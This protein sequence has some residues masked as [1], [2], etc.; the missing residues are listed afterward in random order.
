MVERDSDAQPMYV[1]PEGTQREQG[2]S[3]QSNNI[4]AARIVG[5]T[6][7]TTLGPK[8]MDKMLV[9]SMGNVTITNDGVTIL[10]EME[11]EH[12]AAKMVVEIAKTQE[13][14]VG[15]G[16][17][18]AVVLA[19]ELLKRA[20]SLIDQKI[21]PTIITKGYRMAAEKAIHV[22]KEMSIRCT[23]DDIE[24]LEGIA[25]TAM[26]GKG[27][28]NSKDV[29]S[30]I[31]VEAIRHIS[32]SKVAGDGS[33]VYRKNLKIESRSGGFVEE[34]ELVKGVVLDKKKANP[35]MPSRV[36]SARIALLA[37][38][39]EIKDTETDAK[40]QITR[41]EQM[42]DFLDMEEKMLRKMVDKVKGSGANVVLCQ[43][44]IDDVAQHFLAKEGIL[45]VRRVDRSDM[46]RISRASGAEIVNNLDSLSQESLGR[47]EIV[48]EKMIGEDPMVFIR[49]CEN[50]RSVT[51]LVR[52][53]TEHVVEEAKRALED[54]AGDIS[55]AV[56][57]GQIVGGAGAPEIE[58]SRRLMD[59][60]QGLSGREQLSVKAFA[61]SME[62]I[63]KTLA[64]NAGLDPIDTIVELRAAHDKGKR[65]AG[66]DVTTGG[67]MDSLESGV[68]EPL[69]VKTQAVSSA[70]DVAVLILR[71]DDVISSGRQSREEM[72]T[73]LDN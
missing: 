39:L 16:T 7:R 48:E 17:T 9:D 47:S 72:D 29:L 20:E 49:G 32:A 67:V 13:D 69:K 70:S 28:E 58:L 54:A 61:E 63:P 14:E 66:I 11:I 38:P 31:V 68:A 1:L 40:I 36:G 12:P 6:V 23:K 26:T 57:S 46:E 42:Q 34:T 64:E 3:A 51:I 5:D 10:E 71:I 59:Y 62:I 33:S 30:K 27:A 4:M 52:G 15:D 73:D 19:G 37:S 50:P 44:G 65:W 18:T 21:H 55:A 25:S 2:R 56:E 43:K 60:A 8:G 22:L 45:A 35:G 24:V 53:S 41:P